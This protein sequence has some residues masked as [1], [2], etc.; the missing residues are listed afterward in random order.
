MATTAERRTAA[1]TAD[2]LCPRCGVAR[3][4]DQ[5]YCLECGLQLPVVV[6]TIPA[7]RRRWIRRLGWYPGDFVWLPLL[8]LLV[9]AA[10]AVAAIE[11]TKH[12]GTS[13]SA[14]ITALNAHVPLGE[15]VTVQSATPTS[16]GS[17]KLPAAA[18]GTAARNGRTLW[19]KNEAGWS[20]VIVSYPETGGTQAALNTATKAANAG[21]HQVGVLVSDNF[22]SL[23]PGYYVVF[24]GIYGSKADADTAV[25]TVRQA[26]FGGA[27]SRQISR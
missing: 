6:G 1:A 25:A 3:E 16:T 7:L 15:P 12:R 17:S 27:Y 13:H 8:A 14:V 24:A 26:G 19:P 21:L 9:A 22:A 23:Q 4:A 20:V 11:V 10:G 5:Y 2:G 18:P